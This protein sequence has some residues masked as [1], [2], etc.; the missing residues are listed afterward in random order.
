MSKRSRIVDQAREN[1]AKAA[2]ESVEGLTKEQ[3]IGLYVQSQIDLHQQKEVNQLQKNALFMASTEQIQIPLFDEEDLPVT[4]VEMAI[5]DFRKKQLESCDISIEEYTAKIEQFKRV[6]KYLSSVIPERKKPAKS[7]KPAK[8][9]EKQFFPLGDVNCPVCGKP[10]VHVASKSRFKYEFVPSKIIV[11]EE[12]FETKYCPSKCQD[13][14][15]KAVIMTS[16]P[17]EPDLIDKSPATESLVSGLIY[18]K[19]LMKTPLYRLEKAFDIKGHSLSRQTMS[20]MV[21]TCSDLY[22]APICDKIQSDIREL[23]V[24]HMDETPLNCLELKDRTNSYMVCAT[25]SAFEARKMTLYRFFEGRKQEFVPDVLGDSYSGALMSDGLPAYKNYPEGVKLS[26]MAHARRRF[27]EATKCRADFAEWK[28]LLKK[29]G[30]DTALKYQK[31]NQ[32]LDHLFKILRAFGDLYTI[33]RNF[34]D[35]PV[36]SR[37]KARQEMAAPVFK[38]LAELI[39]EACEGFEEGTAVGRAAAYFLDRKDT[40]AKYLENGIWPID[41]NAAERQIKEFVMARK[42]FLFANSVKGAQ[43][44]AMC[45]TVLVSAV[46]NGLNPQKYLEH[47][48]RTLK[49]FKEQPIPENVLTDLMPYSGKLPE[50]IYLNKE[51]MVL[52]NPIQEE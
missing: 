11:R 31:K 49:Y 43:S 27:Y 41:N 20:N 39:Q 8:V 35:D 40:L 21:Q 46:Q 22:L 48:F 15:G 36:S 5:I 38:K 45:M 37:T 19:Y 4:D 18:E 52:S 16:R 1:I 14:N 9:D 28:R 44:A 30:L 2:R 51:E 3:I 34:Y 32:S 25:S 23:E 13:E 12:V 10:L 33:E 47:V 17:T 7:R 24:V 26:C 29:E 6:K 42:N 50:Q